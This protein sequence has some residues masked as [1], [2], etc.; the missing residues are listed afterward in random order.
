MLPVWICYS[1]RKFPI[2][3]ERDKR[4][5]SIPSFFRGG[6]RYHDRLFKNS[7]FD[8][9]MLIDGSCLSICFIFH[10]FKRRHNSSVPSFEGSD[11]VSSVQSEDN[12]SRNH[13]KL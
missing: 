12:L 4:T 6:A 2:A 3:D 11:S 7:C 10:M 9:R 13:F 1:Q 5:H 8:L